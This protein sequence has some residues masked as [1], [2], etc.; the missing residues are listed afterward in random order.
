MVGRNRPAEV[1]GPPSPKLSAPDC[2]GSL[3]RESS[4]PWPATVLMA[5]PVTAATTGLDKGK[6]GEI[7]RVTSGFG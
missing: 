3:E 5:P 4:G 1:A 7:D 2:R 6:S